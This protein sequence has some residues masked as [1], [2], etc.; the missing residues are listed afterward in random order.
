VAQQ[1]RIVRAIKQEMDNEEFIV[2][3]EW[4]EIRQF[5]VDYAAGYSGVSLTVEGSTKSG[6]EKGKHDK[7]TTGD[8]K[9]KQQPS[10]LAGGKQQGND[11]TCKQ[12]IGEG[13]GKKLGCN[14][15]GKQADSL[16]VNG[17]AQEEGQGKKAR[18]RSEA[19]QIPRPL[20][21]TKESD[22]EGKK[23]CG[24]PN[25]KPQAGEARTENAVGGGPRP[26]QCPGKA[27][28]CKLC[29]KQFPK[30]HALVQ[31]QSCTG[32]TGISRGAP[33]PGKPPKEGQ[34]MPF[35]VCGECERE[36][37]SEAAC[38]Q[39]Q[40]AT[41]HSD[42]TCGCGRAFGS[43]GA[44]QQHMDA[45]GH[46][47]VSSSEDS[48][49]DIDWADQPPSRQSNAKLQK[50]EE[51]KRPE[52]IQIKRFQFSDPPEQTPPARQQNAWEGGEPVA[53]DDVGGSTA[54]V[55]VAAATAFA[56]AAAAGFT[57]YSLSRGEEGGDEEGK[58]RGG[59]TQAR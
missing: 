32:H 54:A 40:T 58:S 22:A 52:D 49:G 24:Q 14:A 46:D 33:G 6:S 59:D 53:A 27:W 7:Q 2:K 1:P 8:V 55:A 34:A 41:G 56:V 13:K 29:G 36:F 26:Y 37:A 3:V 35:W 15:G 9:G 16:V 10:N 30:R 51:A 20:P 38:D 28:G 18:G 57:L 17:Q 47:P 23:T 4:M 11:D 21:K 44:L 43:R 19:K 31:H 12:S 25:G 50:E 48:E 5:R 39:H 45:T 42:P